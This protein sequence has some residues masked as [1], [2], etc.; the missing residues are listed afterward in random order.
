MDN[1]LLL[2][3][4]KHK[5]SLAPIWLNHC[6]SEIVGMSKGEVVLLT[7]LLQLLMDG[8]VHGCLL[9]VEYPRPTESQPPNQAAL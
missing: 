7:N 3:R 4:A 8:Q 6:V 5:R 1:H 9:V 2:V